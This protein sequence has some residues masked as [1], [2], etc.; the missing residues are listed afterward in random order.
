MYNKREKKIHTIQL[1]KQNV[2]ITLVNFLFKLYVICIV[3]K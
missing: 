3:G 1:I 2:R